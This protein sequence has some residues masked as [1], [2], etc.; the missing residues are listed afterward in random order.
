MTKLDEIHN[1]IL[2]AIYTLNKP[3]DYLV[4]LNKDYLYEYSEK[5]TGLV[6]A[7]KSQEGEKKQKMIIDLMSI[8][9]VFLGLVQQ[10]LSGALKS[11]DKNGNNEFMEYISSLYTLNG[12]LTEKLKEHFIINNAK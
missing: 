9:P 4:N 2:T 6:F 12:Y 5:Y 3:D 7:N 11:E 1:K 10:S 8:M